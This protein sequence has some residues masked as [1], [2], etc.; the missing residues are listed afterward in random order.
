G[1]VPGEFADR[2]TTRVGAKI[3][4]IGGQFLEQLYGRSCLMIPGC[5][6]MFDRVHFLSFF[7]KLKLNVY[8]TTVSS[9]VK[10]RPVLRLVAWRI[11]ESTRNKGLLTNPLSIFG[12]AKRLL[13][14]V[15]R[16]CQEKIREQL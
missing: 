2:T 1:Q 12:F 14:G 7:M 4:L 16:F 6:E 8:T 10:S 3:I 9:Q 11:P 5:E 15:S 13:N